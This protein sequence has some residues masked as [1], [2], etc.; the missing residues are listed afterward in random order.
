MNII[1]DLLRV[2]L[3]VTVLFMFAVAKV[4]VIATVFVVSF[5]ANMIALHRGKNTPPDTTKSR[6]GIR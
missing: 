2:V 4:M 5:V 3:R 6:R 1:I